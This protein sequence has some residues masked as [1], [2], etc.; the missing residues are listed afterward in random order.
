MLIRQRKGADVTQSFCALIPS[1][2]HFLALPR[3]IAWLCERGIP[4]IV[5]NDGS[6]SEASAEIAKLHDPANGV[7]VLHRA[8]N[9]GKGT[10]VIDGFRY[11]A[12]AGYTHAVQVDADGQH[13]LNVLPD[14]LVQSRAHPDA[15]V[16]GAPVYDDSIPRARKIGRWVT[17]LWVFVETL[18]LRISDSM[19]GF[20]VYPLTACLALLDDEPLGRRMDFDT[21]IMVRLFWRGV[22]PI[23]VP[24]RVIYPPDNTSNFD[25]LRD[26][27]RITRMHTR[28]VLTMLWRLP[29][30][31]AHRPRAT[32]SATHWAAIGERGAAW[33][34]RFVAVVYRGL[35]RRACLAM[36]LP[37]V[38]YFHITGSRQR[39][40]GRAFL[41][42]ALGRMPSH[43]EGFRHALDFA[44]RAVDTLA[45]WCGA[46]RSSA[47]TTDTP[48][49][50]A[51]ASAETRGAL[52]VVSHH[53]NVELARALM[54]SEQR[55]RL[56]I[57]VHTRHAENFNRVLREIR[58][59]IAARTIQVTDIGPETAIN[60]RER[61]ERGEWVA[62]AGDRVPVNSGRVV[63]AEFLGR[64]APFSQGP[65]VLAGLLNCPVYLLFCH[66]DG[67]GR[68]VLSLEAFSPKIEL[69]RNDRAGAISAHVQRY[70][71][72][73]EFHARR[74]PEQWYNFFDFWGEGGK[75]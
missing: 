5:V 59:E 23:M 12:K 56:T 73:L 33:G 13:D 58:P 18:S 67:A 42:S 38:A 34:I 68:W 14:L 48:D 19:C 21:D 41:A 10:A 45:A 72:R 11:A 15:L 22:P 47:L 53:G 17:H 40:A 36:L 71:K 49:M 26:N 62:I 61:I 30:I 63:R 74:N 24:T 27:L 28:L 29:R 1:H 20:R 25:V 6:S 54:A 9:G 52:L 57:L 16:S 69:P 39:R 44:A 32:T 2:N 35:G 50:L 37:I 46:I 60:L 64:P 65:W 4:I 55:N 51:A 31:L 43:L 75:A 66:R 8:E 3:M 70:A 7:T